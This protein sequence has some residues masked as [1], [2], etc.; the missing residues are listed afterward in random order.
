MGSFSKNELSGLF[1]GKMCDIWPKNWRQERKSKREE[2]YKS[3][4][5]FGPTWFLWHAL[6]VTGLEIHTNRVGKSVQ[7]PI[8]GANG[9]PILWNQ[10][11]K[12]GTN[13]KGACAKSN[14]WRKWVFESNKREKYIWVSEISASTVW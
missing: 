6:F 3:V 12:K 8:K 1:Q 7:P 13:K 9:E 10:M 2:N 5:L 11:E 4:H 14:S